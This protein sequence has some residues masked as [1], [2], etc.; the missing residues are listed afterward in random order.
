MK[1]NALKQAVGTQ[2]KEKM[3]VGYC[4]V[5]TLEQKADKTIEIQRKEIAVYAMKR[6]YHIHKFYLDDGVSGTTLN[7]VG[8]QQMLKE[9]KNPDSPKIVL[10]WA[11]SRLARD[12]V[13]SELI[14]Q[15]IE[16]AGAIPESVTEPNLGSGD[17]TRVLIRQILGVIN[18]YYKEIIVTTMRGGRYNKAQEG[19]RGT[20]K[21]PLGYRKK[22][23]KLIIDEDNAFTI[24]HIFDLRR[25]SHWGLRK[26]ARHLNKIGASTARGG[27]WH[28]TTVR[29]ILK[30]P[31]YRGVIDS[32][33]FKT[34]KKELSLI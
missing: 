20:G 11:L 8:L 27:K 19:S 22:H 3:C 4:R 13:I 29:Y 26:I 18:Q 34:K 33:G 14:I 15:Q 12:S 9:I 28:G 16:S 17:P 21:I 32:Y 31:I 23:K 5:S 2:N 1:I 30:N 10:F 24:R 25:R 6:G 7:R